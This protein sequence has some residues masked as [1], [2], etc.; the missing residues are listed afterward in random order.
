[1]QAMNANC[2][3]LLICMK[4]ALAYPAFFGRGGTFRL[5]CQHMYPHV[6]NKAFVLTDDQPQLKGA[7]ACTVAMAH[8]LG[9]KVCV[10]PLPDVGPRRNVKSDCEREA[11]QVHITDGEHRGMSSQ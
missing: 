6:K 5:A 10:R 11:V 1:M 4:H 9:L 7:D 3:S 8:S 2:V